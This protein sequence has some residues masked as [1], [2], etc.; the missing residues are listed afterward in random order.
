MQPHVMRSLVIALAHACIIYTTT[1]L[2]TGN[3]PN[4][5]ADSVPEG[6]PGDP[7]SARAAPGAVTAGCRG[8]GRPPD[9]R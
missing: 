1:M 3:A 7:G 9:Q 5:T 2:A 4:Q 8:S 6:H